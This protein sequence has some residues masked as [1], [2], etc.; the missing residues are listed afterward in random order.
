MLGALNAYGVATCSSSTDVGFTAI[1][2]ELESAVAQFVGKEDAI[3]FNMGYGTNATNIPALVGKGSL[4]ISDTLNHTSIVN[5]ARASGARVKVF[6]HNDVANLESVLRDAIVS[7]QPYSHR[8]WKKILVM[9]E[10]I[11]SMEG[12][13]IE[14]PAIVRLCKT[15][16]AYLYVDEAHSIGVLGETGRGVCEHFGV[17]PADIDILMGTFTKAFGGMGG[18]IAASKDIIK[19]L[20]SSSAG[21]LYST[22]MSPVLC[23]QILKALQVISGADGTTL[24]AAKLS[25]IKSNSRYFRR[26]LQKMGCDVLG[27][28]CSPVIPV[29][30]YVPS[31]MSLFSRMLYER[32]ICVVVVGFPAVDLMEARVRFCI[33]ASHTREDLTRALHEIRDVVKT[34]RLR[35]KMS[36]FG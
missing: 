14:L 32:N 19:H 13:I 36:S 8:P 15:Y 2:E 12:E 28:E 4:I 33:S 20:R 1:H 9:V 22:G 23:G 31:K 34:L 27:D 10:G 29:M 25:A 17:D 7:G 16:R 5:G 6:R 21:Y 35:Y 3:V 11:Y 18:Y 26:E 24:G 30:L